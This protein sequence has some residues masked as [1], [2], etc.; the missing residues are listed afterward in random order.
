MP[1][2]LPASAYDGFWPWVRGETDSISPGS[3][4]IYGEVLPVDVGSHPLDDAF[5]AIMKALAAG[6]SGTKDSLD[7]AA[8]TY[9]S[10]M[11]KAIGGM[12]GVALILGVSYLIYK[13]LS[14]K[15]AT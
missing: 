3:S 5:N 6:A 15:R 12:A 8:G 1:N 2:E 11:G 4:V 14:S 13:D 7:K 9:A 10:S